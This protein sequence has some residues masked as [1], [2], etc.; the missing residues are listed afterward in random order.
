[1]EN[2][3]DKKIIPSEEDENVGGE[4]PKKKK[5]KRRKSKEERKAERK[6]ILAVFVLV[7]LVTVAFYLVPRIKDWKENGISIKFG[8]KSDSSSKQPWGGYTEVNF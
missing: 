5:E 6:V 7:A 2:D 3:D 8:H 4:P 1:M